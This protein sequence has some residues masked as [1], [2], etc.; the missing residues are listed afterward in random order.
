MPTITPTLSQPQ[1][2]P[3]IIKLTLNPTLTLFQILK[4]TS[5]PQPNR[6]PAAKK[7][8]TDGSTKII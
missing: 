1:T 2:Q 3:Q 6:N 4:L 5:T 8:F 7:S